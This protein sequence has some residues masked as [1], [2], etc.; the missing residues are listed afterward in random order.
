MRVTFVLNIV[1]ICRNFVQTNDSTYGDASERERERVSRV[2]QL[3]A[4]I[5]T[6]IYIC[7]CYLAQKYRYCVL[8]VQTRSDSIWCSAP[9]QL[10]Q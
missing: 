6:I 1:L 7:C 9:I 10:N 2:I 4:I 3:Y 8:C 5:I